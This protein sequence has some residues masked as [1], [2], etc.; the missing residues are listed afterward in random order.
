MG[1]GGTTAL[2]RLAHYE[3]RH[4]I[5]KTETMQTMDPPLQIPPGEFARFTVRV[6][7]MGT[8]PHYCQDELET[9]FDIS[10]EI[11]DFHHTQLG[12]VDI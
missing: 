9:S 10:F 6:I 4:D 5:T 3:V 11:Q 8:P 2:D 1:G 12:S 7:A